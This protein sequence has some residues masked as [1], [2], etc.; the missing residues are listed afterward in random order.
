MQVLCLIVFFNMDLKMYAC[1]IVGDEGFVIRQ[2]NL[3]T[4]NY[5]KHKNNKNVKIIQNNFL[6]EM[7]NF[8]M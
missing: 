8:V 5:N 6:I 7:L 2:N 4:N 1:E 3:P